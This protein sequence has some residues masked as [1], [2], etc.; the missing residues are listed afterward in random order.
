MGRIKH[1]DDGSRSDIC[2]DLRDGSGSS[3]CC[4]GSGDSSGN[5]RDRCD[6]H[7]HHHHHD[8]REHCDHRDCSGKKHHRRRRCPVRIGEVIVDC[9]PVTFSTGGQVTNVVSCPVTSAVTTVPIEQTIS[10]PF[11]T[12]CMA[13]VPVITQCVT[14]VP[15]TTVVKVPVFEQFNVPPVITPVSASPFFCSQFFQL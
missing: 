6:D 9:R 4:D 1:C 14:S 15:I 11:V 8:H 2:S 5:H 3:G 7:D 10:I 13:S 12:P